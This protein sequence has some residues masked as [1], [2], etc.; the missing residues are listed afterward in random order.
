MKF[1][2][3]TKTDHVLVHIA[4]ISEFP[5]LSSALNLKPTTTQYKKSFSIHFK[6]NNNNEIMFVTQCNCVALIVFGKQLRS[7]TEMN[8]LF[9]FDYAGNI[10][11]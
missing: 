5:T 8:K 6:K 4:K 9:G 3:K 7:M 11:E 1:Y 2:E 10:C